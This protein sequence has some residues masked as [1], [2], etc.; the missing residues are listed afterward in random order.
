MCVGLGSAVSLGC[1]GCRG[2]QG[3]QANWS[4]GVEP[5]LGLGRCG[6]W[7]LD[8]CGCA[9]VRRSLGLSRWGLR[10]LAGGSLGVVQ[11]DERL[12]VGVGPLLQL[13][14][15]GIVGRGEQV[16]EVEVGRGTLGRQRL[17]SFQWAPG[18]YW[19]GITAKLRSST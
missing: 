16:V 3:L 13:L 7:R 9:G 4:A 19:R 15:E 12:D 5:A 14:V 8:G 18:K 2:R 11:G 10:C 1:W 17:G 6:L